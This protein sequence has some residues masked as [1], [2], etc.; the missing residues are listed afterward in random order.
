MTTDNKPETLQEAITYFSDPERCFVYA[1]NLRWPDGHI[2]CPRCGGDRHSFI[3]TRLLWFCKGCKKQFTVKVKTIFEDS[4]ITLD[5]WMTVVWMLVNCK[6]GISSYEIGRSIGVTQKTA[7]FMLQ[8]VRNALHNRGFG[9]TKIGGPDTEVEAD[10][11]FVGGLAKNMHRD[12]RAR[13]QRDWNLKAGTSGKA[14]VQ[15]MLDRNMRQVR[16]QVVPNVKRETLQ[17]QILK[18]VR[19]G[20]K[21]YTD[22]AIGYDN[23]KYKF[24][25]DFVN[26]AER[27][28]KGR[29]HTNGMENFWS[30]LKRSLKGTYVAVEPFHLFR[31]VDE[32]VFRFNNRKDSDD[33]TRFAQAM[34][35]IVGRHLT[36]AELTGKNES[37]RLQATGAGETEVPF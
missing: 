9:K 2:T 13:Y 35:Q 22:N 36:Y 28:V 4:P 14:I 8:R 25:H 16:A 32:Q 31:Y 23:L 37:P 30:L 10:E 24:V 5:K 12:R 21:V 17:N 34:S 7:W 27:Y 29:V 20:T 1:V 18:N 3:K 33:S 11:T 19:Y 26:H 15:G 6:N